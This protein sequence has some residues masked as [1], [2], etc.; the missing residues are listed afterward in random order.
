MA[1]SGV[2]MLV[3]M[4]HDPVFGPVV[5]CGGGGTTAE[6]IGDVAVRLTPVTDRDAA[7]MV[8]SL[9]TY[10]LLVGYRGAAPVDVAALEDV[11]L[12]LSALV[13]AHP[14]IVEVD[15][16]PVIATPDGATVVDARMRVEPAPPRLPWPSL[17]A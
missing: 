15:L 3:G 7:E 6:V 14:E 1:A 8:E 12:R 10:P 13:D 2:E 11:V 17:G 4:V 5:A 16:N 9:R